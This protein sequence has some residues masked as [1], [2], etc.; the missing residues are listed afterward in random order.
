MTRDDRSA[1]QGERHFNQA[2][3]S[4]EIP[5]SL[6]HS[7]WQP[8]SQ[9]H[10]NAH[11]RR[12]TAK[13]HLPHIQHSVS[14]AHRKG[15]HGDQSAHHSEQAKRHAKGESKRASSQS[16]GSSAIADGEWHIAKVS[17]YSDGN[18]ASGAR[19]NNSGKGECQVAS[20]NLGFNTSV[21]FRLPGQKQTKSASVVDR[22]PHVK[23]RTFDDRGRCIAKALGAG[24]G[25]PVLEYRVKRS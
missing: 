23:G 14:G 1:N 17:N 4:F 15:D 24:D 10:Y 16:E 25:V 11:R 9:V 19:V 18:N 3:H 2:D 5:Q 12:D 6:V 7:A 22:G 20:L 13:Q 8:G 21:E